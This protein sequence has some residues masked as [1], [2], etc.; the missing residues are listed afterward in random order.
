MFTVIVGPNGSGKTNILKAVEFVGLA[1]EA[2]SS[3]A[4]S[5]VHRGDVNR[6]VS[7]DVSVRLSEE[8]VRN[9]TIATILGF[10]EVRNAGSPNAQI[11]TQAATSGVREVLRQSVH[12]FRPL[13]EGEVHFCVTS[14]AGHAQAVT[15]HLRFS[16]PQGDL[17]LDA[18]N[19]LMLVP[20]ESNSWAGVQIP[21][22]IVSEIRR[23]HHGAF[24]LTGSGPAFV[25]DD[26][27]VT[28]RSLSIDWI[29][30]K[31]APREMIPLPTATQLNSIRLAED[32]PV[33]IPGQTRELIELI[34]FLRQRGYS[35][36]DA[37]LFQLL[38]RIYNGSIIHASDARSKIG[39][40]IS[41]DGQST[42][43]AGGLLRLKVSPDP[44][45]RGQYRRIQRAF[46]SLT[47]LVVEAIQEDEPDLSPEGVPATG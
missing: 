36:P 25:P 43:V 7:I 15:P 3:S 8:E 27:A 44:A 16:V 21:D 4:R 35:L 32:R 30:E 42:D 23:V 31:L 17:C 19:R 33:Q 18:M 6:T 41:T 12:V 40:G 5:I 47:R 28:A 10:E 39:L 1:F 38:A 34:S 29:R 20:F 37:S 46:E 22:E 9:A 11:N 24:N 26:A 13:F 45:A 14:R 2:R